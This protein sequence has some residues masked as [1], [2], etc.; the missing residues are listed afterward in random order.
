MEDCITALFYRWKTK[1]HALC[2]L[3]ILLAEYL[4][5]DSRRKECYT[6]FAFLTNTWS[7]HYTGLP[8]EPPG[9]AVLLTPVMGLQTLYQQMLQTTDPVHVDCLWVFLRALVLVLF[10][11][12]TRMRRLLLCSPSPWWPSPPPA[13]ASLLLTPGGDFQ[14]ETEAF[15]DVHPSTENGED[16]HVMAFDYVGRV[17]NMWKQGV[18]VKK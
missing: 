13:R 17:E 12:D 10:M 9:P 8:T 5:Q 6:P 4:R 2:L 11:F 7:M 14:Q 1:E 16:A 15:L 18:Y 3:K